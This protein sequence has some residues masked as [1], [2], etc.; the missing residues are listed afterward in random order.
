MAIKGKGR[1]KAGRRPV[2]RGPRPGYV[3]PPKPLVRR[4]WFRWT[5]GAVVL[6]GIAAIVVAIFMISASNNRKEAKAARQHT[7]QSRV[8]QYVGPVT[9]YL[10]GV[11][12]PLPGGDQV[13][14]FQDLSTQLQDFQSGKLSPADANKAG[15]EIATNAKAA[16]GKIQA[17]GVTTIVKGFPDLVDLLDSQEMLVE[18]MNVYQ[19]VGAGLAQAA[20]ATGAEQQAL[21]AQSAALV[22]V[23]KQLFTDGYQKLINAEISAGLPPNVFP[24]P[25]ASP[26]PSVSPQAS[27]S[28]SAAASAKPSA[29]AGNGKKKRTPKPSASKS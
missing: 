14:A 19:Q 7:R 2:A 11:A 8:Q 12:T 26:T 22:P 18:S 27:A 17:L 24:A 20:G 3:E 4:T 5:A 13:A 25:A 15:T 29:G 1:T 16:A 23:A 9:Q 21:L 10:Q 6:A 28:P